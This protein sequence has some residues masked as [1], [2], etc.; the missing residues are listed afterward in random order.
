[1]IELA[2]RCLVVC[3]AGFLVWA[4]A[5]M[6]VRPRFALKML[7]RFGSTPAIHFT[8]LGLRFLAG[9]ALCGAAGAAAYTRQFLGA[10]VFLMVSAR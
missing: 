5:V 9:A 7:E 1:M 8:E 4:G 10:G 6:A 3:F 2:A